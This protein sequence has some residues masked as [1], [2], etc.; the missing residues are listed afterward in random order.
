[1][2]AV[3]AWYIITKGNTRW[4]AAFLLCAEGAA[5]THIYAGITVGISYLLLLCY[6]LKWDRKKMP[7][8][9]ILAPLAIVFY[10]PWLFI[11]I[12]SFIRASKGFWIPPLNDWTIVNYVLFIFNTDNAI[13][14]L[15]FLLLFFILFL[16]VLKPKRNS[17]LWADY[18]VSS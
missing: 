4:Y 10:L 14:T 5:Y 12:N 13:M 1:M 3:S 17:S 18:P 11:A 6:V 15:V 9:F 16:C 8:T 7:K 2:T